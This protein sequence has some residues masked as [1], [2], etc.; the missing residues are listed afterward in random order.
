M[1]KSFQK[2]RIPCVISVW[3]NSNGSCQNKTFLSKIRM[4]QTWVL[5][6]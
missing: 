5:G 3:K 6:K 2:Y 4:K 1:I